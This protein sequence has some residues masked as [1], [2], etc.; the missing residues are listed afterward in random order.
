MWLIIIKSNRFI[1]YKNM[2]MINYKPK[3]KKKC[4]FRNIN[5]YTISMSKY[6]R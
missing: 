5:V 4:L 2:K 3:K 6:M 1:A